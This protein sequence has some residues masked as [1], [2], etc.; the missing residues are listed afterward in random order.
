M[1]HVAENLRQ[2]FLRVFPDCVVLGQAVAFNMFLAFFPLLLFALGVLSSMSIFQDVVGNL[3]AQIQSMLPEGSSSIVLDYFVRRTAHPWQWIWLGFGGTLIAG[4]QVFL[5]LIQGFRQIDKLPPAPS[6][7]RV[8]LRAVMILGLTI[9]PFLSFEIV[10][11]FG[12]PVRGWMLANYGLAPWVR[13]LAAAAYHGL[14]M[15]FALGIVF[16]IYRLGQPDMVTWQDVFPGA[17]V[18][19]VLWWIV[20]ISFGFY[21]RYVPYGTVYRGLAAVIGLLLWMYLTA[22]V[23][24]IGAAYNAVIREGPFTSDTDLKFT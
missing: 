23:I 13:L 4:T 24:F 22:M 14:A 19:T 1:G 5:G 17:A 3:P 12:R 11:I 18:A 9:I 10:T 6:Y 20:D 21:V 8:Q 7:L 16:V 2:S 15:I